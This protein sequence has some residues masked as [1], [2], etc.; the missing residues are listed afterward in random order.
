MVI[1]YQKTPNK[2]GIAKI[3]KVYSC[4]E[5]GR[6]GGN[7]LYTLVMSP[8]KTAGDG[9][10]KNIPLNYHGMFNITGGWGGIR[11]PG[12]LATSAVFKTVAFDRS[13][14]HPNFYCLR[15]LYFFFP[16]RKCKIIFNKKPPGWAIFYSRQI[17]LGTMA[18]ISARR[19]GSLKNCSRISGV[20]L[21][22][23]FSKC[24]M[25]F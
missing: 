19:A 18:E 10:K 15:I 16:K 17:V 23:S 13:A 14:T 4:V 25:Y 6:I 21:C 22:A 24:A 20:V 5:I 11:T 7:W 3:G 2:A 12:S 8:I 9:V 1:F